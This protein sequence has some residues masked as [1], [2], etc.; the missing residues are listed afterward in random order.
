MQ[1]QHARASFHP[2]TDAA[3]KP[4]AYEEFTARGI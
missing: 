2:A 1:A 4:T 3:A